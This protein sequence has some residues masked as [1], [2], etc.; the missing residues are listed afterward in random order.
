MKKQIF[1]NYVPRVQVRREHA[2]TRFQRTH[3][4]LSLIS[5]HFSTTSHIDG[6]RC[7]CFR[8]CKYY[9]KLRY[10][11]V[12]FYWTELRNSQRKKSA[13]PHAVSC[14]HR[15]LTSIRH[16]QKKN[17]RKVFS[18]RRDIGFAVSAT[19][20]KNPGFS[21]IRQSAKSSKSVVMF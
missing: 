17:C 9:K 11:C 4:R 2:K 5:S 6:L 10:S 16:C 15:Q 18:H 7:T 14:F 20:K 21:A 8:T 3:D 12:F 19:K 1:L 13:I